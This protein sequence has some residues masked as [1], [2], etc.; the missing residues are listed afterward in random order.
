MANHLIVHLTTVHP[1]DDIRIFHKECKS[2]V[3]AGYRVIQLVGDGQG[4]AIVDGVEIIDIGTSTRGRLHR[5]IHQSEAAYKKIKILNPSLIHFHDPELLW[6]GLKIKKLGIPVIYD[7][8]EDVPRQILGKPWITKLLRPL[9]SVI[10]EVCEN[11]C[12]KRLTGIVTPTPLIEKRFSKISKNVACVCN[13]PFIDELKSDELLAV[14]SNKIICYVGG[15]T[16]MRGIK[17]IVLSLKYLPD[18]RLVLCGDF[19]D[20]QFKEELQLLPEWARVEYLGRVDRIGV[21]DVLARS[22]IGLVTLKPAIN[23]LDSLPI[24]MFEYMSAG[25]PVVASN[26]PFWKDVIHN[27]NA[28]LCEC[29]ILKVSLLL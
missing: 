28:G 23:Y 21:R 6:V 18:F 19:D 10:F 4:N 2:L 9:I 17:E 26:F 13:F 25:L 3:S 27:S 12:A 5:F 8:H 11:Y 16:R 14:R 1:R 29:K 15:L 7:S 22:M 24:K 20:A